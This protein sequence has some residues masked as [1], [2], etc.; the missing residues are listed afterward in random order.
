MRNATF[1]TGLTALLFSTGLVKPSYGDDLHLPKPQF[2]AKTQTPN[3]A[4]IILAARRYAAFWDTGNP[5]F[6]KQAL[7]PEFIDHTLPAGRVQ[8]IDGPIQAS[9]SF[10]QAIPDLT[11]TIAQLVV[12]DDR[13]VMHLQF[14]GHFTGTFG[15]IK[16]KGQMLSFQAFDLYR[17]KNGKIT[18]NWHLEDNQSLLQQMGSGA[19]Q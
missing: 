1:I 12:A 16:G 2:I 7:A 9:E 5:E 17:V 8:G 10:R 11:V 15:N 4:D 6:A 14:N 19:S 13:V 3:T 18:D